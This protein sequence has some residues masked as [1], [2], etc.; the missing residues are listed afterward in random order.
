MS[1]LLDRALRAGDASCP[2]GRKMEIRKS[3]TTRSLWRV[4]LWDYLIG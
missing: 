2:I 4:K 3:L 1:A